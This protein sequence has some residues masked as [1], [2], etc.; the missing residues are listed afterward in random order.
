MVFNINRSET[1]NNWF[2]ES[3]AVHFSPLYK[4]SQSFCYT[5]SKYDF[6]V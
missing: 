2:L 3:S 1:E 6:T 4:D 5:E